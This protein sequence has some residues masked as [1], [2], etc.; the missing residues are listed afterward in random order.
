MTSFR[1]TAIWAGFAASTVFSGLANAN[2][3][4]RDVLSVTRDSERFESIVGGQN[5]GPTLGP[6]EAPAFTGG[7][8]A[9]T[10]PASGAT[11]GTGGGQPF[12]GQ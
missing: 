4:F 1:A 5:G 12:N 3:A 8:G 10:P 6:K 2:D 9:A 7:G 11:G